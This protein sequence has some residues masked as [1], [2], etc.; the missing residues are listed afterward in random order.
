MLTLLLMRHGKSDWEQPFAHDRERPLA[1]RGR[2]AAAR[3]GSFLTEVGAG[4]ERVL[5]SPAVRAWETAALA[6]KGGG[7]NCAPEPVES[8]YEGSPEALVQELRQLLSVPQTLL[9]VGHEPT[10]SS[11]LTL[12]L[13]GGAFRLPTAAVAA[14]ELDAPSWAMLEP[15]RCR[16]LWLVTPRLLEPDKSERKGD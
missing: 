3:M 10:G 9:L 16:L 8:L 15:G 7:W 2:K 6:A 13:G 4:P 14:L 11:L 5:T 1:K 12:L